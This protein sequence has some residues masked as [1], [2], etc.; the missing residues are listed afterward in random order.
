MDLPHPDSSHS[1]LH[2]LDLRSGKAFWP[3]QNGLLQTYPPLDRHLSTDVVVLG[4]GITGALIAHA[5]IQA[6]IPAVVLEKRDIAHG[7]TSASTALLQYEIDTPLVQLTQLLGEEH[8]ARAY[9]LCLKAIS[10]LEQIVQ[11][12]DTDVEFQRRESFYYAS[13]PQDARALKQEHALRTKH[14]IKVALWD[15]ETI[16]AHFPFRKAAGLYSQDAAQV[17]P[18]RL[19]HALLKDGTAKGLQVFDRTEVTGWD[20]DAFGVTVKTRRGFDVRAKQMVFATGYEAQTLLPEQVVKLRNSYALISEPISDL[21]GWHHQALLWETARPY[22][23]A[24]TTRDGRILMGGED[25]TFR[26]LPIRER[27]IPGKQAR[28]EKSFASLFPDLKLETAYAWA[29]TFGETRDG[30]AYIG[31]HPDFPKAFFA[32]GYGGNGIVYSVLAAEMIR[33][34][35]LRGHHPDWDV[36]RFDR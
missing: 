12:L 26:T 8:A 32:L 16:A 36:F 5:L 9:L 13:R 3:I 1:D 14:G 20:T 25:E 29:G 27:R 17:D 7:S 11:G 15:E 2:S 30:L 34:K 10:D 21:T 6:G 22:L 28:L 19:T 4:G 31:E 18:H 23:Y 24:R 33:D 35:V